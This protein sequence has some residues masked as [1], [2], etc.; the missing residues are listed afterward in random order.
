[1]KWQNVE[2]AVCVCVYFIVFVENVVENYVW[3]P[4]SYI[5]LRW[6]SVCESRCSR[7]IIEKKLFNYCFIIMFSLFDP[8]AMKSTFFLIAVKFDD[9]LATNPGCTLPLAQRQLGKAPSWTCSSN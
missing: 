9:E 3:F 7:S 8:S 1:M 6:Q 5:G 2:I 4:T